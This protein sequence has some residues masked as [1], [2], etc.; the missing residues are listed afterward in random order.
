MSVFYQKYIE[1]DYL[2][3]E[4]H[5]L[6]LSDEEQHHLASLLDSSIHSVILDEIL[7]N[8]NEQD[9]KLFIGEVNKDPQNEKLMDFLNERVENIEEKIKKV[10]DDLVAEMHKDVIES[11]KLKAKS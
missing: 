9:K 10:A 2:I 6:D 1:I 4:L 5:G 11:K 7:A 8:L 3:E